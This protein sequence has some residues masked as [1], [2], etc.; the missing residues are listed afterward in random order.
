MV[1]RIS[2][3]GPVRVRL[4]A[5]VTWRSRMSAGGLA[6]KHGAQDDDRRCD[7]DRF[8]S[9]SVKA[10]GGPPAPRLALKDDAVGAAEAGPAP[11]LHPR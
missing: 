8:A 7:N 1:V 2:S 10:T 9:D 6:L 4:D 3:H 5:R 11:A